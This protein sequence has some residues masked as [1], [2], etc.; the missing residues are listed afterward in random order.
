MDSKAHGKRFVNRAFQKKKKDNDLLFA[1]L[2]FTYELRDQFAPQSILNMTNIPMMEG[3]VSFNV[4]KAGKPC[5]TYYKVV[6]DLNSGKTP[7][8]A[9]HGGSGAG[10]EYLLGLTDLTE[11]LSIPTVFYDQIGTGQSTHLPE[12]NSDVSFWTE[13]L[14]HDELE[15]SLIVS[16]SAKRVS[17]SSANPG[18]A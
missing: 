6:G 9:L 4:P 16:V 18:E 8:I 10:H 1:S 13:E 2:D 11:K 15:I 3:K 12:K 14:F 7:I 17:I 5:S